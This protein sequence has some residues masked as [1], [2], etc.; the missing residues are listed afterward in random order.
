MQELAD[1]T[2]AIVGGA[3]AILG[4]AA[5]FLTAWIKGQNSLNEQIDRRIVLILEAKDQTIADQRNTINA[6]DA[7]IGGLEDRLDARDKKIEHLEGEVDDLRGRIG[8]LERRD[9]ER[10]DPELAP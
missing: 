2:T 1:S 3:S 9:R 7:T 6:R 4:A 5:A 8:T 10:S